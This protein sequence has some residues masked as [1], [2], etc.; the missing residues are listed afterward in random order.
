MFNKEPLPLIKRARAATDPA[1]EHITEI[2]HGAARVRTKTRHLVLLS[3]VPGSGKTLVGLQL[4]HAGWLDDLAVV[5]G[6]AKLSNPAVYLLGNG[7]LVQVLQHAL[8]AAG[9]R[10]QTFVQAIKSYVAYHNRRKASSPPEHLIVF[11]EAQRAHDA[12]RVA[13]VHETEVDKSEPEHLIEFCERIPEWC[14]LVALIG[15]GQAIHIGEE[16]GAPLWANAIAHATKS[17]EWTVHGA[18]SFADVF[19]SERVSTRW[20]SAL[21]LDT[22]IRFHL[23]PKV[24]QFVGGLVDGAQAQAIRPIA[25]ELF[26]K[27]H[28]FLVTRELTAA[29]AYLRERYTDAKEAR[30]GVLASSKDKWLQAFGV[31]NSFQTTKR[32]RVGPRYNAAPSDSAS[33]CQ[34]ET[35]A[36]EFSSQGLELD[37]AL[38]AWGSDLLWTDQGWSMK[39]SRGTRG[40]LKDPLA[41]RRNVYRVLLTRGRDGTVI[42]LPNDSR[43]DQTYARLRE[44]GMRPLA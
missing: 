40:K 32:L 3:G 44:V 24:H 39:D 20:S 9:G 36:T 34:L 37:C 15:D 26:A 22:E 31:D 14:V 16:G 2:A 4:V 13:K 42:F 21:N 23:T 1:L 6:N 12:E 7:P 35:V 38:V 18:P 19:R 25:D 33:C 5:R 17:A 29:K 10:G 11:D 28:R 27:T 30:F 41:L 43:F 8:Q